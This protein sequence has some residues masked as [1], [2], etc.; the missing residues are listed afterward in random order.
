MPLNEDLSPSSFPP[1]LAC[2][3]DSTARQSLSA[4]GDSFAIFS[5]KQDAANYVSLCIPPKPMLK[6]SLLPAQLSLQCIYASTYSVT[7]STCIKLQIWSNGAAGAEQHALL[8]FYLHTVAAK[9]GWQSLRL[10]LAADAEALQEGLVLVLDSVG[11][12]EQLQL[13][14]RWCRWVG[15]RN[16]EERIGGGDKGDKQGKKGNGVETRTKNNA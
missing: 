13:L 5:L 12:A 4:S 10:P 3:G 1:L 7:T 11:H 14:S 15:Y 9:M 16:N 8:L 2:L 6:L